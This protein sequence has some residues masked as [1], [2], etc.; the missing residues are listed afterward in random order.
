MVEQ[1]VEYLF[2]ERKE[3]FIKIIDGEKIEITNDEFIYSLRTNKP[4]STITG[5]VKLLYN[6]D[7][8]KLRLIVFYKQT[9]FTHNQKLK[10]YPKRDK[11]Y[12]GFTINLIN[13][14]IY[15]YEIVTNNKNTTKTIRCNTFFN[16]N[17][18]RFEKRIN[19]YLKSSSELTTKLCEILNIQ[20]E[21]YDSISSLLSAYHL[22]NKNIV[23]YNLNNIQYFMPIYMKNRKGYRNTDIYNIVQDIYSINN[24]DYV[25][26]FF[27][28]RKSKHMYYNMT[29][30]DMLNTPYEYIKNDT[31]FKQQ[32]NIDVY[33]R[34][35]ID[36][37]RFIYKKLESLYKF[38]IFDFIGDRDNIY[39]N[40]TILYAYYLYGF[41]INIENVNSLT[42]IKYILNII[43]NNIIKT[44]ISNGYV[45][46]NPKSIDFLSEQF[47]DNYLIN[48]EMVPRNITCESDDISMDFHFR[49]SVVEYMIQNTLTDEI[50]CIHINLIDGT[51]NKPNKFINESGKKVIFGD[52]DMNKLNNIFTPIFWFCE[53][54]L[55]SLCKELKIDTTKYITKI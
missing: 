41:K 44:T 16:H 2:F 3:L 26:L 54:T 50:K 38:N 14:N 17:L 12:C 10:L 51:I 24:V 1:G 35:Y 29:M 33:S 55:V 48:Y 37:I 40:I 49:L 8:S 20:Q 36:D 15:C 5:K 34:T 9:Q 6:E 53:D 25:K 47:G 45:L 43:F 23:Y 27:E 19:D 4:V 42:K 18:S 21:Y 46:H 28:H 22:K 30:F 11:L 13:K 52:M 39:R 32:K 31:I 7:R